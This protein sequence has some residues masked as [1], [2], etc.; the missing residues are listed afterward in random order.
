MEEGI[1]NSEPDTQIVKKSAV[2]P[3]DCR[4]LQ[5]DIRVI[6]ATEEGL[7]NIEPQ[8]Q[9]VNDS[10]ANP[11]DCPLIT[12]YQHQNLH[13]PASCMVSEQVNDGALTVK[14]SKHILK[15][16][17]EDLVD[18]SIRISGSKAVYHDFTGIAIDKLT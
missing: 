18:Q 13:L 6:D 10:A 12:W 8:T 3:E 17:G 7:E 5:E 1:N 2:N 4:K 9:N 11:E 14:L 16:G 15:L